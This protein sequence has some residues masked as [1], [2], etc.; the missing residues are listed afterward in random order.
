M[1]AFFM[2]LVNSNPLLH[3]ASNFSYAAVVG[4]VYLQPRLYRLLSP[5]NRPAK[6]L[7]SL[8]TMSVAAQVGTM[9]LTLYSSRHSRTISC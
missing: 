9:P 2:L 7:W 6:W 4:I 5:R 1:S 8:L 3:V